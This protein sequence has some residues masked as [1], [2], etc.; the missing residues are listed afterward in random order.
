MAYKQTHHL[1]DT[2]SP[3]LCTDDKRTAE[4]H[5]QQIHVH[6]CN[7]GATHHHH[8]HHPWMI[9]E[10]STDTDTDDLWKPSSL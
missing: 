2:P 8:H 9:V 4:A 1:T 7:A 5:E 3:L 10:E 6:V